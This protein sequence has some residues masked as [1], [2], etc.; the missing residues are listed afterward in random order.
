MEKLAVETSG[1]IVKMSSID[2]V[3]RGLI[4]QKSLDLDLI[5]RE[6]KKVIDQ[7]DALIALKKE[8]EPVNTLETKDDAKCKYK[9]EKIS[10]EWI[11]SRE[12]L[13]SASRKKVLSANL[14]QEKNHLQRYAKSPAVLHTRQFYLNSGV[15][16]GQTVFLDSS[17]KSPPIIPS[18]LKIVNEEDKS[19]SKAWL[20]KNGIK[21]LK[22]NLNR[23]ERRVTSG[24]KVYRGVLPVVRDRHC[25]ELV[26]SCKNFEK[27]YTF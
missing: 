7:S 20:S 21:A 3:S 22:I 13:L 9:K 18:H 19:T 27:K 25:E 16:K 5:D 14:S 17:C 2:D 1:S 23:W 4:L 11:S 6:M 15:N 12:T 8:N 24:S 10:R 26:T